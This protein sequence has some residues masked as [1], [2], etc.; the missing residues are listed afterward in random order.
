MVVHLRLPT[1]KEVGD[2]DMDR[3]WFVADSVWTAKNVANDMVKRA[4]L[5]LAF[6]DKALD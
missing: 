1:L 6:E 2:K 5:S 3:F 4:Q